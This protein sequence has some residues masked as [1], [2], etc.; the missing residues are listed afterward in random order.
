MNNNLIVTYG[1]ITEIPCDVIVNSVGADTKTYG[2]I[3]QSIIKAAKSQKLKATIDGVN[4]VYTIGEFFYTDS[5]EIKTCSKILHLITPFFKHDPDC[6]H[7]E[8]CIRRILVDCKRRGYKNIAIPSL[9]TG[10][11]KY[12]KEK[13]RD[14]IYYMSQAFCSF[15]PEMTVKIVYP[16]PELSDG[17]KER[18][19]EI[20]RFGEDYFQ[21]EINKKIA[22]QEKLFALQKGKKPH[23][24]YPKKYFEQ[25]FDDS[26]RYVE[27][28]TE[29]IETIGEYVDEYILERDHSD[30]KAYETLARR[31]I[32]L[33]FGYGT[34][35]KGSITKTGATAYSDI[36]GEC[37]TTKRN[38]YRIIFALKMNELEAKDFLEF[39]GY[40]FAKSKGNHLDATALKLL[41]VEEY[42]IVE[43]EQVFAECENK[44]KLFVKK[45]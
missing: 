9:G 32:K 39:F 8:E 33:F 5:Y 22:K 20:L 16:L 6:S 13:V 3:C 21:E 41:R 17:N 12:D 29:G 14:I 25:C 30:V 31:R 42:G 4:D 27:V 38:F 40:G 23:S 44:Y 34:N 1:D 43:I 35:A 18:L 2:G 24:N 11:N 37:D 36:S 19:N 45:K 28:D 15:Y 26:N 10:A 7:Y